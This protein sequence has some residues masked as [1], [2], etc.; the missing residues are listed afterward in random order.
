MR[1]L[2]WVGALVLA[3]VGCVAFMMWH[4][5]SYNEPLFGSTPQLSTISGFVEGRWK[6][7]NDSANA[8]S[9]RL[10]KLTTLMTG[11]LN[12]K[13]DGTFRF[14]IGFDSADGIWIADDKGISLTVSSVNGIQADQVRTDYQKWKDAVQAGTSQQLSKKESRNWPGRGM[15]LDMAEH[16]KRLELY[17][18]RKC[19]Y[20]PGA[21][22]REDGSSVAGITIWRR[23]R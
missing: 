23:L 22:I 18:T 21:Y 12:I 8:D 13:H 14:T 1:A 4:T 16:A 7:G 2:P 11:Q 9:K 19:L 20:E 17:G 10:A 15:A 5:E 3:L 6:Q